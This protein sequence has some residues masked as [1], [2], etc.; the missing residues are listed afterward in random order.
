MPVPVPGLRVP[1]DRPALPQPAGSIEE[2]H[3]ADISPDTIIPP[4][5]GERLDLDHALYVCLANA[6]TGQQKQASRD[7]AREPLF[8]PRK[9]VS[10][11]SDW[12]DHIRRYYHEHPAA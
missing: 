9:R 12:I 1:P 3:D 11:P 6:R 10:E 4:W 2:T 5:Y 7:Q 8:E